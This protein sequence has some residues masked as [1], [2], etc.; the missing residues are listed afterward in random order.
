MTFASGGVCRFVHPK[1]DDLRKGLIS[2]TIKQ[3]DANKQICVQN[4]SGSSKEQDFIS[5]FMKFG[6]I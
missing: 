3:I 1:T 4:C 2:D 5:Y 6:P